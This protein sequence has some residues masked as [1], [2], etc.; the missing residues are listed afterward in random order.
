MEI[1]VIWFRRDMRLDDHIALSKA[2]TYAKKHEYKLLALYH[3]DPFFTEMEMDINNE[4]FF[5]NLAHFVKEARESQVYVHLLHDDVPRAFQ[6][7]MEVYDIKAVFLMK[8]KWVWAKGV[9][10]K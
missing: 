10:S 3:L 5:Q 4:H 7:V 1:V 6:Q 2:I 9:T 8:M